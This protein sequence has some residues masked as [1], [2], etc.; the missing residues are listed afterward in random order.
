MRDVRAAHE[1]YKN[2]YISGVGKIR[3]V[4]N[5]AYG[6][7]KFGKRQLMVEFLESGRL[8]TIVEKWVIRE[9]VEGLADGET[10]GLEDGAQKELI[11]RMD[12]F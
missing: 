10:R 12:Y 1:E 8:T 5:H 11:A 3:S 9:D 4:H 2:G 7:T 6:L